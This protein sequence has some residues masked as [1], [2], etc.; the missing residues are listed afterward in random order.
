MFP[1][2][3]PFGQPRA[4]ADFAELKRDIEALVAAQLLEHR[5]AKRELFE[6]MGSDRWP[7]RVAFESVD[8]LAA[9][10]DRAD[11]LRA[12]RSAIRLTR[13][14]CPALEPW[15]R[16]RADRIP[17]YSKDWPHLLAV[18][19]YFDKHP[20]PNC[21]AR[22]VPLPIGTKF[23]EEHAGILRELLDVV[24]GDEV[25]GQVGAFAERFHLMVDPPQVRF[26]LLDVTLQQRTGWPV[27]DCT[28]SLPA[29]SELKWSVKRTLIV[30]NRD[31]FLCLP[32]V[33]DTVAV[34][35]SGK[36]A[37]LLSECEWMRMTD[38][39][40]W[41]DCDEAGFGILSS[42]RASFPNLRSVLMDQDAWVRWRHLATPGRR[43]P[44]SRHV[45][46]TESERA[47]LRDVLSGPLMLE[48]ERI[49]PAFAADAIAK[50]FAISDAIGG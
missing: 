6:K 29:F 45:H 37:L 33:L 10:L 11:E 41:G 17:A 7:V 16:L 28:I 36:A 30:E 20:H 35:G 50:A 48:Q 42:L 3:I 2:Q 38:L 34:F 4:T 39:V 1:L 19:R 21:F 13:E 32:E 46:L 31:V 43:D 25:N 27:A 24:L 18:C 44:T 40:Y 14:L 22:Q 5:V 26:R 9:A 23:I 12:V 49:P 8:S 15:L 47:A